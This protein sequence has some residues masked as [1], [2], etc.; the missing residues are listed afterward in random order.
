[1]SAVL[2]CCALL[3]P[4]TLLQLDAL[5]GHSGTIESPTL[6]GFGSEFALIVLPLLFSASLDT[7]RDFALALLDARRGAAWGPLYSMLGPSSAL[8]DAW[9]CSVWG[10]HALLEAWLQRVKCFA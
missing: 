3:D 9:P 5:P 4:F 7:R 1:M 2:W 10:L 8:I 6:L